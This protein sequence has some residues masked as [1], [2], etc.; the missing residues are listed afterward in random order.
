MN[1]VL[2]MVTVEGEVPIVGMHRACAN[3]SPGDVV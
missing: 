3:G 1:G 2:G